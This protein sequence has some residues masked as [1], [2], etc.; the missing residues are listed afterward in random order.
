MWVKEEIFRNQKNFLQKKFLTREGLF[1][2]EALKKR[3]EPLPL[4]I[5]LLERVWVALF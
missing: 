4:P 3:K 2:R 1:L 5:P